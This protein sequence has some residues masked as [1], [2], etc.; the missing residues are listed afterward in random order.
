MLFSVLQFLLVIVSFLYLYV[1]VIRTKVDIV[2][3]GAYPNVTYFVLLRF[4]FSIRFLPF[5][6][7]KETHFRISHISRPILIFQPPECLHT[8][9]YYQK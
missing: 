7:P 5:I 6:C 4:F 3:L 9:I 2:K 1:F 8:I